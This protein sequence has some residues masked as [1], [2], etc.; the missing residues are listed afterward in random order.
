MQQV[1]VDVKDHGLGIPPDAMPKMFQKY[2]RVDAPDRKSIA[3]TGVGLFLVK[4]LVEN[5]HHGKIWVESN[6]GHGSD[7]IFVLPYRQPE[8]V[9]D[10][11]AS[12]EG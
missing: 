7:F 2:H 9:G 1:R 5:Y 12:A 6:Y 11:S 4:S 10:D 3:G 8:S